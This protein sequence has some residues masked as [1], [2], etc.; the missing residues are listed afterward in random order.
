MLQESQEKLL[1]AYNTTFI[2]LIPKEENPTTF[3]KFR[4]ISLCNYIYKIIS[5]VI[6]RRLKSVLSKQISREQFGFL[7]G[8]WIQKEVGIAQERFHSIKVN[9]ERSIVLE[10]DLSKAYDTISWLYFRLIL[11]QLGFY[12]RFVVWVMRCITLLYFAILING[13]TSPFFILRRDLRQGSPLSPLI[14]LLI[15]E[16]LIV[17]C[18]YL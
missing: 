8:R 5:K 12:H 16:G 1:G 13:A 14:F 7:E 10:V 15:V 17:W 18:N 2:A 3:E 11:I 6:A 9:T 4:P